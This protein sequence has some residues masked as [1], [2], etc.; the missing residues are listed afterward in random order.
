M[1]K[2]K[3]KDTLLTL[4]EDQKEPDQ[5]VQAKPMITVILIIA[6]VHEVTQFLIIV[7]KGLENL[8]I[9]NANIRFSAF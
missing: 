5:I 6:M 8:Y 9:Y 2:S 1:I 7:L 3:I 4:N